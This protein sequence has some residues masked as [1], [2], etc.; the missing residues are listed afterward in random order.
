ME[1]LVIEESLEFVVPHQGPPMYFWVCGGVAVALTVLLGIL[2][3]RRQRKQAG[4]E[5]QIRRDREKEVLAEF[6]RW[7]KSRSE[8]KERL[9]WLSGIARRYTAVHFGTLATRQTTEELQ[10]DAFLREHLTAERRRQLLQLWQRDDR[11]RFGAGRVD[12]AEVKEMGK[13]VGEWFDEEKK[14]RAASAPGERDDEAFSEQEKN[15]TTPGEAPPSEEKRVP[16][17]AA[18]SVQKTKTYRLKE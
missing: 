12:A 3:Y 10:A 2:I 17:L 11:V 7:R 16:V 15:E 5:E 14:K 1:E 8:P 4:S 6:R 13:R 9:A 18:R